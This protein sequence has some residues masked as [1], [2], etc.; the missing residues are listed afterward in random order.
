MK[1]TE[2]V[3]KDLLDCDSPEAVA[4]V[5]KSNSRAI[6][7]EIADEMCIVTTSDHVKKDIAGLILSAAA[8]EIAN[9]IKA[10]T[11]PAGSTEKLDID[12]QVEMIVNHQMVKINENLSVIPLDRKIGVIA[13]IDG[14]PIHIP[15]AVVEHN[16]YG[17]LIGRN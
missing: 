2:E 14:I 11:T 1:T 17:P 5:V 10:A 9:G 7:V 16:I 13:V 4:S 12:E 8:D 6:F 3:K 15:N